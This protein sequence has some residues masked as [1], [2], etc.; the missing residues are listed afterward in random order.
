MTTGPA[1]RYA[2]VCTGVHDGDTV[3]LA[4][5]LGFH[6]WVRG[7]AFRLLDCNARELTEPGGL[8]ARDHLAALL[9]ALAVT[10]SSVKPD[11]YG[12]RFLARVTMPDGSDLVGGLIAAQWAGPWN[13][14]GVK[15]VPPWPREVAP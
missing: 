7:Q 6:V 15:P 13:G 4:V 11:K 3:E 1:Y 8:E 12:G 14:K 10:V 2:A 5:D 9:L